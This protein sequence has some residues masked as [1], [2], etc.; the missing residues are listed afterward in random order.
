MRR[1]AASLEQVYKRSKEGGL[2]AFPLPVV[3]RITTTN[4]IDGLES[5]NVAAALPGSDP[6]LKG[7]YVVYTAHIDAFGVIDPIKGDAIYNGAHDNA[8]GAAILIEIARAFSALPERPRRAVLFVAVTG[9]EWGL[10][11]SDYFAEQPTVPFD[12]MV[13]DISM[14]MPF[15]FHPLLDVVPYGERWGWPRTALASASAPTPS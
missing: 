3:A 1:S 14:D 11:G 4:E 13:A 9:E 15:L 2:E 10:L 6:A 12:S 8:S 5:E 7:E